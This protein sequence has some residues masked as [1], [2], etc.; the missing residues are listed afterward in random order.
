VRRR[1]RLES[2]R[3]TLPILNIYIPT[4]GGEVVEGAGRGGAGVGGIFQRRC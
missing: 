3:M 4:R 1:M 2:D